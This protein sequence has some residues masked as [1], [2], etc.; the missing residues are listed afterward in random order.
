[1]CYKALYAAQNPEKR[2]KDMSR[3]KLSLCHHA[4]QLALGCAAVWAAKA[5]KPG[6]I[7]TPLYKLSQKTAQFQ[8]AQQMVI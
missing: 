8:P 1:M 7:V 3:C 4:A 6:C 2:Q 5:K